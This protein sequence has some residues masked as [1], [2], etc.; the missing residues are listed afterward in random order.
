MADIPLTSASL[1]A[2]LGADAQSARWAEFVKMYE[3]MMRAYLASH[4]PYVDADD[5]LQ[6]TFLALVAALPEYRYDVAA[7]G[8]FRNYLTGVLRHKALHG[9]ARNTRELVKRSAAAQEPVPPPE[10]ADADEERTWRTSVFEIALAQ[11]MADEST[12]ARTK[13]IFRRVALG[14]E[15]PEAVASAFDISRNAVD[16]IKNRTIQRLRKTVDALIAAGDAPN[17]P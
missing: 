1:L 11:F 9:I 7:N 12:A 2:V 16:Q 5:I 17:R 10:S 6:E 13:E 4:F 3:P 14:G 8:H 15:A